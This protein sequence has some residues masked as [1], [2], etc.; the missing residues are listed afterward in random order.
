M[1]GTHAARGHRRTP[2]QTDY[3][4]PYEEG[5]DDRWRGAGT[6]KHLVSNGRPATPEGKLLLKKM[7]NSQNV[8]DISR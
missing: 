8:H 4:I 1:I 3:R 7:V 2:E 5:V 6:V